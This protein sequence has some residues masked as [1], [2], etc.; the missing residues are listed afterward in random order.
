MHSRRFEWPT[1]GLI[2]GVYLGFFLAT[3]VLF[4]MAPVMAVIVLALAIVLHSSLMH[5]VLHGHPTR[6][7]ALNAALIFVNIGLFVPYL[8]FKD[9]HLEH[10]RD[11]NLTDPYD[12]P[13]S[14]YC[15]PEVWAFC[16]PMRRGVL[17]FNN[18]LCGR[19]LIG[20]L[21]GQFSFMLFDAK[22]I[23]KGDRRVLL[24]WLLHVPALLPVVYW[25]L[26]YGTMPVA[27]YLTS[28]YIALSILKI[29]TFLEHRAHPLARGRSVVI[30]QQ[31]LFSFLFLNNSYHAVH[32]AHPKIAWY[33]LPAKFA[34]HRERYLAQ[35]EGYSYASYKE[36]LGK[37][38]F[39]A[40][41]PVAHP[42]W[43]KDQ[44]FGQ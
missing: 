32:H 43:T 42:I 23:K 22:A 19:M 34:A 6:N 31:C 26:N 24:G 15:D 30:E 14:N 13:E 29:R 39:T 20:P 9:T 2:L 40:K 27:L 5:E 16:G 12:D 37:Y 25:I 33:D 35:N 28:A 41:D 36:I 8:R 11:E 38:M 21:I 3:T 1:L 18:T 44:K 17:R 7:E 10:H 4:Q